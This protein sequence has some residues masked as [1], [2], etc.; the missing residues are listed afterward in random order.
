VAIKLD[1]SADDVDKVYR[2]FWALERLH[3]LEIVY[4]EIKP[5]LSSFLRLFKIMKQQGM[6]EQEVV[7]AV[8]FADK[9]INDA[10]NSEDYQKIEKIAEEKVNATLQDKKAMLVTAL[11]AILET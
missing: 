9:L 1:M 5:Y 3:Q 8:K 7:N 10:K 11:I 2:Q 4:Y 6:G